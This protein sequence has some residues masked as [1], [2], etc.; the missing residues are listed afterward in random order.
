MK[1]I[2]PTKLNL[3]DETVIKINRV[4]QVVSGGRTFGFNAI[5]VVG[6]GNGHVGLGL[7]K[8]K[9]VI[10]AIN[11]G[12]DKAKKNIVKVPVINGTIPHTITSNY[13]ASK[14]I[15]KPASPGTGIIAGG[16]VRAVM[17]AVGVKDVLT[18]SLGSNNENN[19]AKAAIKALTELQAPYEVAKKRGKTLQEIFGA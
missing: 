8:A 17:E 18:K 13:N 7:G 4:S 11:K 5:V 19:I 15:L 2:D 3:Q 6:D 14:V 12:K 16:P 10:P 1:I 9:E